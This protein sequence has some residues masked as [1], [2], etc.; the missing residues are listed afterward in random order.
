MFQKKSWQEFSRLVAAI[1]HA[2]SAGGNVT[3]NDKINGHQFDVT[4]RYNY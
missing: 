2:Q 4:I 1:Y 3:W